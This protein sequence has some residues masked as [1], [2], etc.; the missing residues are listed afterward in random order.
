MKFENKYTITAL[1]FLFGF[2]FLHPMTMVLG[3]LMHI[4]RTTGWSIGINA[5]ISEFYSSFSL[6]MLPWGLL[7]G[8]LSGIIGCFFEVL[9]VQNES[10]KI[11]NDTKNKFF[12]VPPHFEWVTNFN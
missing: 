1:S 3:H 11:A 6:N 7:S 8:I 9:K 2:F 12:S 4:V 5:L 10:L